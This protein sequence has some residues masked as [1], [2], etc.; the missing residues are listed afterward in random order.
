MKKKIGYYLLV[1]LL[2]FFIFL[3][4]T[5]ISGKL[6]D[7]GYTYEGKKGDYRIDVSKI[8]NVTLYSAHVKKD[9]V[10]YIYHFRNKPEDLKNVYLEDNLLEKINRPQGVRNVYVTRDI[11]I[12]VQTNNDVILAGAPF[13]AIL[14]SADYSMYQIPLKNAYTT[15]IDER[16]PKITCK[17]VSPVDAVIY[18]RLGNETKVYS[19]NECIIV[20]GT[21]ADT[22]IKAG[23]KL[24]YYLIGAY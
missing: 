16:I 4:I 10:E 6:L 13:E 19:E 11:E 18:M 21:D 7:K 14:G 23:E 24:G 12:N 2:L 22:L 3:T 5:V 8:G 15:R 1:L 17:N 20:Q 9:N